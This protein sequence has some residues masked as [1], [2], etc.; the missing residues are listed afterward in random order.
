MGFAAAIVIFVGQMS[1]TI[2]LW[3]VHVFKTYNT[4]ARLVLATGTFLNLFIGK[5]RNPHILEI[6]SSVYPAVFTS[7]ELKFVV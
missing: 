6:E 3:P 5:S 1:V 7:N 2:V 4:I